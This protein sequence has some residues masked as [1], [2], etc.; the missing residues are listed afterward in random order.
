MSHLCHIQICIQ[1]YISIS[2]STYGCRLGVYG[3][4]DVK[5]G[6]FLR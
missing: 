3:G 6:H 5:T 2:D 4:T 1:I